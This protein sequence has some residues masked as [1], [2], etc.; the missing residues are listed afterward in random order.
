MC[1]RFAVLDMDDK[2]KAAL[3]RYI[4]QK[5]KSKYGNVTKRFEY[6]IKIG[7]AAENFEDFP[8]KISFLSGPGGVN[9]EQSAA[10]KKL[11]KKQKDLLR[12]FEKDLNSFDRIT[13]DQLN[14]F[15]EFTM[16]IDKRTVEKWTK[17]LVK[18]GF[19]RK[20]SLLYWT[21]TA[22]VEIYKEFPELAPVRIQND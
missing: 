1:A 20:D 17:Y 11:P 12:A 21:N 14:D 3:Y 2:L 6:L 4:E 19:I 8:T 22:P 18:I 5:D 13:N 9:V 10:H 16:G 7:L 15:L